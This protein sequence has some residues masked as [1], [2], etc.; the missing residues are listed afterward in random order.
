MSQA[1]TVNIRGVEFIDHRPTEVSDPNRSDIACFVGY[2]P[3]REGIKL[4]DSLEDWLKHRGWDR[5]TKDRSIE[6]LLSVP[7]PIDSWNQFV[8]L[9]AWDQ[10][11][12]EGSSNTCACYLGAAVRTFFAQ[13]GRKCYVVRVGDPTPVGGE[14]TETVAQRLERIVPGLSQGQVSSASADRDSWHGVGHLFGLPDVSTLCLPDLSDIVGSTE[15]APEL[16]PPPAEISPQF[17]DCTHEEVAGN[18]SDV[19]P[20]NAPRCDDEGYLAWKKAL[21][22]VALFLKDHHRE[23][24]CVAAIPLPHTD[25]DAARNLLEYLES[26]TIGLSKGLLEAGTDGSGLASAFLQLVYPWAQTRLSS[27]LPGAL[28]PSDGLLAGRL[29]SGALS[30]GAFRSIANELLTEV[31]NVS[32]RLSRSQTMGKSEKKATDTTDPKALIERVTLL[33]PTPQGFRI[34][35]DVTTSR[36]ES[37]RPACVNRLVSIVVRAVRRLGENLTFESSSERLWTDLKRQISNILAN[38]QQMGALNDSTGADAYWVECGPSTMTQNDIENGR[39]IARVE[40][41]ASAIVEKIEVVLR[42]TDGTDGGS[43]ALGVGIKE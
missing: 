11:S 40:F 32:P 20:Y 3:I 34:V 24:Q 16:P 17:V 33:A 31:D 5:H 28:E 4:P 22:L 8:D 19:I 10:R 25:C 30:R 42:V 29:A 9:F 13:G 37:Y 38:L 6:E 23:V 26:D 12:L 7:V 43:S 27:D 14:P 15:V 36:D 35:S 1:G 18:Q 39:L 41:N 21:R 2:V